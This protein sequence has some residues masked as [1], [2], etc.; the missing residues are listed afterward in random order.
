MG[1]S[2]KVELTQDQTIFIKGQAKQDLIDERITFLTN[3]VESNI[4]IGDFD[5]E[6]IQ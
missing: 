6:I 3:E 2:E 5:K 1:K 4:L